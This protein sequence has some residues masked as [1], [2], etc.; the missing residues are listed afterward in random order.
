M[1]DHVKKIFGSFQTCESK[2]RSQILLEDIISNLAPSPHTKNFHI[3]NLLNFWHNFLT[4][5]CWIRN[6]RT[7][8]TRENGKNEWQ[9]IGRFPMNR[10]CYGQQ[11]PGLW[12]NLSHICWSKTTAVDFEAETHEV[13]LTSCKQIEKSYHHHKLIKRAIFGI[14]SVLNVTPL[15]SNM[16]NSLFQVVVMLSLW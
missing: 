14:K 6:I 8:V 16:E 11:L 12:T 3:G 5:I 4:M 2:F 15:T 1:R 9:N 13:G 7:F 10:T